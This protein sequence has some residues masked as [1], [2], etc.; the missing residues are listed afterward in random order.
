M[1]VA[2]NLPNNSGAIEMAVAIG[3]I[4][5]KLTSMD[6]KLD[7]FESQTEERFRRSDE[8]Q[9]NQWKK[10]SELDTAVELLKDRRPLRAHWSQWSLA[11]AAVAS[12]VLTY[13]FH[14]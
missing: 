12:L 2:S 14:L 9:E 1:T 11:S 6:S 5:E 4:E 8:R 7:K 10:I 13:V 3:R